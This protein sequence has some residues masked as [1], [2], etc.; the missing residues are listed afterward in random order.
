MLPT[1][2]NYVDQINAVVYICLAYYQFDRVVG[3]LSHASLLNMLIELIYT[4]S[5]SC[6]VY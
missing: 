6:T 5:L 3:V 1:N 4:T 2:E